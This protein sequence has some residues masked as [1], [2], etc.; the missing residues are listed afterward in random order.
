MQYLQ[1]QTKLG[2][3]MQSEGGKWRANSPQFRQ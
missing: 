2:S 1:K 3:M